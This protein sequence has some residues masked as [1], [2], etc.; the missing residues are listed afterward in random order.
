MAT[1]TT[2]TVTRIVH[3]WIV[4]AAE[5][6][7]ACIGDINTASVVAARAYCEARGLPENASLPDD[8]LSFHVADGA[9]VI[10]FTTEE[11]LR[12]RATR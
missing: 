4:P 10:S 8:A 2:E 3:R 6:W 11:Q 9:I 7:G 12:P 5:P 1:F